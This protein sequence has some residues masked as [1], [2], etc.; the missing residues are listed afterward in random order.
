MELDK[1]DSSYETKIDNFNV[2]YYKEIKKCLENNY[3]LLEIRNN[4]II[5]YKICKRLPL[6][7]LIKRD[8]NLIN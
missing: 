1:I 5:K 8:N 2:K 7:A 6:L 4:L 3:S